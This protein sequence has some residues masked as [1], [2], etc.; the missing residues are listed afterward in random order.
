ADTT[1]SRYSYENGFN[2]FRNKKYDIMIGT[3]MIGKGLDFPD[4]TLVGV[5]SVDGALYAG[6]FRAY[7]RTFSLITQVVGRSGR[8]E[9]TGRA[10]LQ[11][12]NP[13][14]YIINLA[15]LQDYNSFYNEEIT[16]RRAMIFPPVC[17][18]CIFGFSG[19]DNMAVQNGAEAVFILMKQKLDALQP[20]TPVKVTRP[21]KCSY[22]KINGRYRW[23]IIMKCRNTAEIRGFISD[24]LKSSVKLKEMKD[25]SLFADMNGDTGI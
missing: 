24:I 20:K 12:F 16:L 15:A 17:D 18:L 21:V 2:D 5:L 8:G 25:I 4:V 1:F 19:R 7:E 23:R 22:E 14:H 9:C 10:V 3:Q 13:E 6:D 11:T